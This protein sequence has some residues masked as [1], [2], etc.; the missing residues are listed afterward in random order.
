M[1]AV[2]KLTKSYDVNFG[3]R[4]VMHEVQ[5]IAVQLIADA[6]IRGD[7]RKEYVIFLNLECSRVLKK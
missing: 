4:S 2:K 6:H 7:L 3:V 1:P 5:R